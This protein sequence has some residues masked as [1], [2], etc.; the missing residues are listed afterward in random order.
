MYWL[1]NFNEGSSRGNHAHRN[2]SQ[3]FIAMTG[4]IEI[5]IFHGIQK[6]TYFLTENQSALHLSPG[7]WRVITNPSPDALVMVLANLPY[8]EADYIR[9]WDEYLVWYQSEYL[10][11]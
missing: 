11:G 8:D 3:I 2:L 4:T 1:T 6:K 5:E 10:S 9:D 7:A